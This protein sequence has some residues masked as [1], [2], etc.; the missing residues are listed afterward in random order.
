MGGFYIFF[1]FTYLHTD[2]NWIQGAIAVTRKPELP[3]S[4]FLFL[5][6]YYK[7]ITWHKFSVMYN[8]KLKL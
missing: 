1:F 7:V 4:H 3:S 2:F 5:I 6:Y 8:V